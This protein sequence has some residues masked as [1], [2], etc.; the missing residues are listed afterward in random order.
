MTYY[1][2]SELKRE[3]A[4]LWGAA[5]AGW[6]PVT[7]TG[8]LFIGEAVERLGRHLHGDEWTGREPLAR[9]P[10]LTGAEGDQAM[11]AASARWQGVW[12]RMCLW[13]ADGSLPVWARSDLG[14][15]LPASGDVFAAEDGPMILASGRVL[16]SNGW[17]ASG[18]LPAFVGEAE[19][20][21]LSAGHAPGEAPDWW[22]REGE[23]LRGWVGRAIVRAEAERRARAAVYGAQQ[24][25]FIRAALA[26]WKEAGQPTGTEGSVE[27]EWLAATRG[28]RHAG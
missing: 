19:F 10:V 23:R 8:K 13:I 20:A 12:K 27:Q 2:T 6:P 25:D 21:A 28:E 3:A 14:T 16:W 11:K 7:P 22:P 4:R 5:R 9:Q 17:S 18:W 1:R 15:M 26:M 24:A